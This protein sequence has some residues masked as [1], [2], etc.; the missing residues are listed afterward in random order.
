MIDHAFMLVPAQTAVNQFLATFQD[1]P[2]R[3]KAGSFTIAR[4]LEKLSQ[5]GGSDQVW[6]SGSLPAELLNGPGSPGTIK[7]R[8][9]CGSANLK[10]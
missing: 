10:L 9:G 2:P 7:E 5:A 1:F 4:A 3:Q 8:A 6:P